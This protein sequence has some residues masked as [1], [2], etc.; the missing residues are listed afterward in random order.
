MIPYLLGKE[1]GICNGK[2]EFRKLLVIAADRKPLNRKYYRKKFFTDGQTLM[3]EYP[4]QNPEGE[5]MDFVEVMELDNGLIT[6]HRV[7]WGWFGFNILKHDKY[8]R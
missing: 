1:S 7:Y 3:W 8:H 6:R 2:E 5:Q 4:R